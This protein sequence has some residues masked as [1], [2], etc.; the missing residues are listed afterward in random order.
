MGK[1]L[2]GVIVQ[3]GQKLFQFI[4]QWIMTYVSRSKLQKDNDTQADKVQ[5]IADEIKLLQANGKPIPPEL[6]E[7]LRSESRKLIN[8]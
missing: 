2:T 6:L 5:K 1:L 3:W 8:N 4:Y 7:K